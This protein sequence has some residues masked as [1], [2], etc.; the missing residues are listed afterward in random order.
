MI[1]LFSPV[2]SDN[3]FGEVQT[4]LSEPNEGNGFKNGKYIINKCLSTS[5]CENMMYN[6]HKDQSAS[7]T[8]TDRGLI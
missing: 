2:N 8:K 1:E 5:V 6:C 3:T 4:S 7:G